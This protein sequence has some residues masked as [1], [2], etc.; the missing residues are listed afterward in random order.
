MMSPLATTRTTYNSGGA[1]NMV[2]SRLIPLSAA[3]ACAVLLGLWPRAAAAALSG[4]WGCLGTVT[5]S[6]VVTGQ[7]QPQTQTRSL[8]MR[9]TITPNPT[10]GPETVV[11]SGFFGF[12]GAEVCSFTNMPG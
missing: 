11:A 7:S 1:K 9:L 12:G 4:N 2:Q 10:G 3:A 5:Y 6:F 8:L